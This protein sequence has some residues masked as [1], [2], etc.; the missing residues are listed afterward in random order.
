MFHSGYG[1]ECEEHKKTVALTLPEKDAASRC[2][3]IMHQW[4]IQLPDVATL[5]SPGP[6]E[7]QSLPVSV[8]LEC[9]KFH[10]AVHTL[11]VK[12][13][14][15]TSAIISQLTIGS[16]KVT[17]QFLLDSVQK[18]WPPSLNGS[19]MFM[20]A[21]PKDWVRMTQDTLDNLIR[22]WAP[23]SWRDVF[24]Q[25]GPILRSWPQ[26]LKDLSKQLEYLVGRCSTHDCS[27][28]QKLDPLSSL[29][30]FPRPKEVLS[31]RLDVL[32]DP[33]LFLW[34]MRARVAMSTKLPRD[35]LHWCLVV[36]NI[37]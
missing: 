4:L 13:V 19:N 9:E 15:L 32:F 6:A 30:I 28:L 31:V 29:D 24:P 5:Y 18:D 34:N 12:L 35:E 21:A 33:G 8:R 3:K 17:W 20:A 27:S 16:T 10:H 25:F 36:S 11:F 23:L 1:C 37:D 14:P 26:K 2:G 22:G 7:L